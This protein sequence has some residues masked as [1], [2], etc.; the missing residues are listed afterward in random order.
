MG[1]GSVYER[2]VLLD[3]RQGRVV[4]RTVRNNER[5]PFDPVRAGFDNLPIEETVT[6]GLSMAR[7]WSLR[8]LLD[9]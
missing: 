2:D 3:V 1:F 4:G 6:P 8:D 9:D 5:E 7:R